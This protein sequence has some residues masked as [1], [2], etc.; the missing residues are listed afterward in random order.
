MHRVATEAGDGWLQLT[1]RLACEHAA[2]FGVRRGFYRFLREVLPEEARA[3][4]FRTIW[5]VNRS[6]PPSIQELPDGDDEAKE[7]YL[8]RLRN[9]YTHAGLARSGIHPQF[10]PAIPG[11]PAID[12]TWRHREQESRPHDWIT[13]FTRGW[14]GALK[15]AVIAGM[16]GQIEALA[17]EER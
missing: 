16:R 8:F 12:E 5:I 10:T 15:R 11:F 17:H 2:R 7:R 3:D 1:D 14:P 13:V 6:N 9:E 4:L